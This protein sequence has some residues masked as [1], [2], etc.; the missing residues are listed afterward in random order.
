VSRL[1]RSPDVSVVWENE[2]EQ[3]KERKA[4]ANSLRKIFII[5]FESYRIKSRAV[6]AL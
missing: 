1:K 4:I 5:F 2:M 6:F 3:I